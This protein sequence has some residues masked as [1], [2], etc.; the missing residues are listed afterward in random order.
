M[1]IPIG[2]GLP[3]D[4]AI[5][6]LFLHPSHLSSDFTSAWTRAF[7]ENGR[8]V[9]VP[10]LLATG[11]NWGDLSDDIWRD[12]IREAESALSELKERC[13]NVFVVGIASAGALALR[14]TQ[15]H[16]EQIDGV[17][18]LEPSLPHEGRRLRKI[19]KVLEEEFYFIDQPLL[20]IFPS[21][22]SNP[23]HTDAEVISDAVTSSLIREM[24][25]D[26]PFAEL[27]LVMG[28]VDTFIGEV[29]HGFWHTDG[30]DENDLIDAEFEAIVAGLS[31]DESSPANFLDDLDREEADE[32]FIEPNPVLAPIADRKRR[33]A[34]FA[35]IVGPVYAISAA[36]AGFNPFGIEPWPGLVAFL[37]GLAYF[38]YSLQEERPVDGDNDDGAIL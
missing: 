24:S 9:Q 33:N 3:I 17:I 22:E 10:L 26:D 2:Q 18:L 7:V 5:G 27:S 21:K 37:A 36:I 38:F 14:L 12:W 1:G 19:W 29:V 11:E 4:G 30:S 8:H 13:E 32:H 23:S 35:M 20:L 28:E 31:L 34:I 15:M 25:L 16:S 6:V